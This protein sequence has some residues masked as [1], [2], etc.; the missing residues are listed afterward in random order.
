MYRAFSRSNVCEGG[1]GLRKRLNVNGTTLK[2]ACYLLH[3]NILTQGRYYNIDI[4]SDSNGPI[5]NPGLP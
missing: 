3:L 1:G 4:F 5:E 2:S